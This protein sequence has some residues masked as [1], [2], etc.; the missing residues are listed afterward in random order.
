MLI[1]ERRR[2]TDASNVAFLDATGRH[3]ADGA[4]HVGVWLHVAQGREG[5]VTFT[6]VVGVMSVDIDG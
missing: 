1:G 3:R 2:T 5:V 6:M 4:L